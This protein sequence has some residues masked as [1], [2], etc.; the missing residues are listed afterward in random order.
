[1]Y[2]EGHH[3]IT[4]CPQNLS[5]MSEGRNSY[6]Y[7]ALKRYYASV[8]I[9]ASYFTDNSYQCLLKTIQRHYMNVHINCS[10]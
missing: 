5:N 7:E 1:M 2:L 3:N 6:R 10:F 9:G 8:D 4:L